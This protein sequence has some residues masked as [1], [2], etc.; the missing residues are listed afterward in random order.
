MKSYKHLFSRALGAAPG[1]LHFAAHSHHLWPDASYDAHMQ[2]WNDAASMA[3]RK[4][5]KVYAEVIPGAQQNIAHELHLPDPGT[6]AF[7]SN[8]HELVSRIFSA[9]YDGKPL[10]V[11]TSDGEFH[12]F[13][14]QSERW[15]EAG[16]I[17][18]RTIPCEPFD[19]FTAR[20]L[21]AANEKAPDVAFVSHVMYQTGLRFDG[22]ET[23]AALA[24]P[25]STWVVIDGYHAFMAI[26]VDVSRAAGRIFYLGGGYKYA[27]AG[28]GAAF[29]HTPPGF[30]PRPVNT[31]WYAEFVH[32]EGKPT[33]VPYSTD[34]MRYMGA[35][36]D[37]SGLY[38]FNAVR[39]MLESE[40]LDTEAVSAHVRALREG[41]TAA[42]AEG[43]AGA[44]RDAVLLRPNA[45][46]PRA[47]YLALRDRRATEWRARL[48]E[49]DVITDARGDVL[50]IGL[51]LYHDAADID[52]FCDNVAR[53]LGR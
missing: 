4:W 10:D 17:R 44:L 48:M 21:A 53:I 31:G 33:G 3:D 25:E 19:T 50:R 49:H 24:R 46:E 23:L 30:G 26:P 13:R 40:G 18:R 7:A 32:I 27:M 39:A 12:S 52:A 14:R 36:F 28:E 41:L 45:D 37:V 29:L 42:I 1:G 6:I 5:E 38:R 35:T 15:E 22:I 20:Y 34:G 43:R 9:K 11:L 2:A 51:G 8:T 47:R 16:M